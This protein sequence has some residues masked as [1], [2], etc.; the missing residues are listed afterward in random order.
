[1][2]LGLVGFLLTKYENMI[3]REIKENSCIVKGVSV[4]N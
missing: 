3:L 1:M 4:F 2:E